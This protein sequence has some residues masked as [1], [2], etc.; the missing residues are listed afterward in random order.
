M[1]KAGTLLCITVHH[2]FFFPFSLKGF[3]SPRHDLVSGPVYAHS[4][5]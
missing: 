5:T 4:F 2:R 3:F 1:E